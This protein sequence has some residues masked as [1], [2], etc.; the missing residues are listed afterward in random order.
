LLISIALFLSRGVVKQHDAQPTPTV[1]AWARVLGAVSKQFLPMVNGKIEWSMSMLWLLL[2]L[3]T[4]ESVPVVLEQM[5]TTVRDDE[6]ACELFA[7]LRHASLTVTPHSESHV[8]Q[9]IDVSA[10]RCCCCWHVS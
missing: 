9:F 10:T 1:R 7:A 2:L 6:A 4:R 5:L 8:A 3:F